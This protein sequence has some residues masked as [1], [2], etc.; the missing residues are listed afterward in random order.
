MLFRS[1]NHL[2]L[3]DLTNKGIGGK[4]AQLLLEKTGIV[5]NKN[6]IPYDPRPPYDPSGI[7][8]GTPALTTRGMKEKE[9]KKI[10]F[11]INEVISNPKSYLKIKKEVKKLC[12][13]FPIL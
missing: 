6:A 10:A 12:K 13:R 7:R 2:V 3:V 1:D 8:L 4:D 5:I 11:W 9:M